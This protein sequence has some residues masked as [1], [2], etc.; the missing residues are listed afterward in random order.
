MYGI[1]TVKPTSGMDPSDADVAMG[2]FPTCQ[3]VGRIAHGA[4][5]G[6]R[7]LTPHTFEL[8]G[9]FVRALA[10]LQRCADNYK[11]ATEFR[12]FA[13]APSTIETAPKP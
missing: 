9:S 13:E 4:V 12:L 5:E 7:Y 10:E 11:L 8:T 3:V 2:K 6:C 1:L